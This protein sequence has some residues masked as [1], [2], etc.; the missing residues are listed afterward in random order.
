MAVAA[1]IAPLD[2]AS[3]RR[4][5]SE[6][7]AQLAARGRT[8]RLIP[9]RADVHRGHRDARLRLPQAA[10]RRP[11]LPAR[12]RRAG[13]ARRPLVV[14]RLQA[15]LACCAGR[16]AD[17]GD[18][19]ALAAAEV[20]RHRQA[21]LPG[22]PPFAGGAVG[23]FGYDCV[24]AVERAARAQPRPGRPARHGAD[25]LRRARRLRPPQAH[26]HDPRQRLRRRR[27]TSRPATSA[28]STPIAEVRE[29]LA[30]PLPRRAGTRRRRSREFDAQHAARGASRR[31]SRASSSTSTPATPSRS[32]RRSAGAAAVDV[33]PFSIYRGLRAVNPSPYMYFLDFEDFQIVG[34]SPEPLVTVTGG[35]VTTRPIAGTRPRGA[36]PRRTRRSR[37]ELLADEK[38]RAEHVMLVDLGRNDLGRVCEYGTRRGRDVHGRR[39]LLARDAHRLLASPGGCGPDVGAIDAL[40]SVLPGGHALRRAEGPRDGDHRRARAGQARRLRRRGRLPVLHRATSTPAS[41]SAPSSCK[42]GVA[43]I[44][45]GGGTVADA[46]PD[47]EYEESRA[48]ARGVVRAIELAGAP[49]GVAVRVLVGRQLRLVHLQPRPVPG[50][51]G[52]RARGRAQRRATV[53]ELLERRPDRVVVSPGPCTPE[54]GRHLRRGHAPLPRGRRAD[55]GRLPRPPVARRRRSAARVVRHVPVHGKTTEIDARRRRACSPACRPADRRP[56]PL[57]RR[58]SA[59]CPTCLVAT[60]RGGGVLMAMRHRE[61]PALRRAVPPRVGADARTASRCC[62]NFLGCRHPIAANP[63]LTE[64]IDA[65]A[66][67]TTC[68]P[69]RRGRR[70]RRDHGR[71]RVRGARPPRS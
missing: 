22:L 24:R 52:A 62:E 58:R 38:E 27:R 51:A 43:H 50:R 26:D 32:S 35:R 69:S 15:A 29:R 1:D 54:R 9:V 66:S 70:A 65:L 18:P 49:A 47:Y 14:H 61:L 21:P 40:R 13:P 41:A 19:Y 33:E 3:S 17:G 63:V 59:T 71:Q 55:A 42:D 34:A 31:W 7:A 10:R 8:H 64:A 36:T 20:E 12:V 46:K 67:G 45:A 11:G 60:A 6:V 2:R 37:D 30:G 23:F 4:R 56:L 48:K 28:P 68:R 57:A 5:S 16:S 25:A 53:D 39:D 44:Q